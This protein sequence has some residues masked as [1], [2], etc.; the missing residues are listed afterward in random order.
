[1]ELIFKKL[2]PELADDFIHFFDFDAFSDHDEWDGCYC[3]ESHLTKQENDQL[4]GHKEKRREKAEE[5]IRAGIMTGYLIYDA[6]RVIGWC[7]TGDKTD[8]CSICEDEAYYTMDSEKGKVKIIY[9][10]DIAPNY[11]GRGIADLIVEKVIAEA[12]KEG[13]AYMEAYPFAD[14]DFAFQYKG[15]FRLYE[16]HGFS[17]YRRLPD[18]YIM[19]K[20]L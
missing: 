17:L 4:W 9:C 14:K 7:N 16:K 3:L 13:F 2:N 1:M 20:T 12:K 19:R 5:L 6:Y 10:I 11:R 15:P 18:F 8:Y